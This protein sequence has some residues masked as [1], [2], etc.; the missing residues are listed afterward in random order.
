MGFIFYK[1]ITGEALSDRPLP[2]S[3]PFPNSLAIHHATVELDMFA[4]RN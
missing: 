3:Q 4:S 1:S 2:P